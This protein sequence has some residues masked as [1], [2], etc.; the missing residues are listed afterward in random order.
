MA[1]NTIIYITSQ[2]A[3]K[4]LKVQDWNLAHIRISGKLIYEKG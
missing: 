2:E 3:K 1:E 4:A